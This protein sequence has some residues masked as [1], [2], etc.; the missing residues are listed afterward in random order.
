MG[1]CPRYV[2]SFWTF[3]VKGLVALTILKNDSIPKKGEGL[4]ISC[5][6]SSVEFIGELTITWNYPTKSTATTCFADIH[7]CTGSSIKYRFS[8]DNNGA[9]ATIH[10]LD[11]SR[12]SG[13]WTCIGS[14]NLGNNSTV[15]IVYTLP[16]G[17]VFTQAPNASVDLSVTSVKLQ[18]KT[19]SC[20]YPMA[21]V[22]WFYQ[23]LSNSTTP[24]IYTITN[25][26]GTLEACLDQEQIYTSTLDLPLYTTL[27]DNSDKFVTFSCRIVYLDPSINIMARGQHTIRFAVR[28]TE[29]VLQQ[30]NKNVT[31]TLT[32]T[33]GEL[34]TLTCVTATSRPAPTIDWYL[35]SQK[36]GSGASLT[37]I[38]SDMDH[39]KTIYC[40]AYNIDISGTVFS[41]KPSLFVQVR[42]TEAVLQ[43]NNENTTDSLTVTSGDSLTLTCVTPPSRPA[44]TIDWY[45][46]SERKGSGASLTFTPSNEDHNKAIYCLAYNINPYQQVSSLKSR[47]FVKVKVS[48]VTLAVLGSG[49]ILFYEGYVKMLHCISSPSRPIASIRW[50][51]GNQQLTDNIT[52]TDNTDISGLY[53]LTSLASIIMTRGNINQTIYCDGYISDQMHPSVSRQHSIDVLYAPD[54]SVTVP[55]PAM[56]NTTLTVLCKARGHPDEYTFHPWKQ[57]WGD[58]V[59][60]SNLH[61]T[62]VSN[63]NTLKLERL[64]HQDMGTYICSVDNSITG[65]DGKLEQTG[66]V[67][68]KVTGAPA[69]LKEEEF[70]FT[71]LAGHSIH[72]SIPFYSN[73]AIESFIFEKNG[74]R[75][76]NN[77]RTSMNLS[78]SFIDSKFYGIPIKLEAAKANLFIQNLTQDDFDNY[79]LVLRNF[80]GTKEFRLHLEA[81]GPPNMVDTFNF[82]RFTANQLEFHFKPGFNGGRV[83]TFVIEYKS[84]VSLDSS[85]RNSSVTDLK[86]S[87]ITNGSYFVNIT[88]PPPGKYEYRMY[89]WNDIGRGPHSDVVITVFIPEVPSNS[90]SPEL[91]FAGIAGGISAGI[92]IILGVV[93]SIFLWRRY[94]H[95]KKNE[96]ENDVAGK[97]KE[98]TRRTRIKDAA[99]KQDVSRGKEYE[100]LNFTK[101]EATQY[102]QLNDIAMEDNRDP[103]TRSPE[104]DSYEKLHSYANNEI[105]MYSLLKIPEASNDSEAKYENT[106]IIQLD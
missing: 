55:G 105:Q 67:D 71:E 57:M 88:Q 14:D 77:S 42:V 5:L 65:I 40:Q 100:G 49:T 99:V 21:S 11:R 68:L 26:S 28:V 80:L 20:M 53:V 76:Q 33:A 102:L 75:L 6:T 84:I 31:D 66:T 60:R 52:N 90:E 87:V 70:H 43:Q 15:I 29:A 104:S 93:I 103:K 59:I 106:Q 83:Q 81:A 44:S 72:I 38:P 27:S 94:Q 7:A 39:S 56:E 89:S 48:E 82:I 2:L 91:P 73:P 24:V 92:V 16:T 86:E 18:C 78:T 17:V 35:G 25:S 62:P 12:D 85:W 69:V 74:T 13:T 61:G 101:A 36:K 30:N 50:W 23:D 19:A 32:V 54:M 37:F 34:V 9:Y 41:L 97:D 64:S 98:S 58:K 1:V 3:A 22:Q 47:L 95:A 96:H 46:G 10:S 8:A 79:T 51:L 4:I 45:I 63:H